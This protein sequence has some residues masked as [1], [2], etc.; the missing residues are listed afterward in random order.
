MATY[1]A[2]TAGEKDAD[3]PINVSLI[4]KLDQNPLAIAEGASGAPKIQ[5][6]AFDDDSINASKLV[7]ASVD[8]GTLNTGQGEV[9]TTLLSARLTL[10]GGEYG[11][12]PNFK[13]SNASVRVSAELCTEINAL[14]TYTARILLGDS[15]ESGTAYA[16]QRYINASP[17]HAID[18]LDYLDFIFLDLDNNGDVISGWMAT[19]PPWFHNGPTRTSPNATALGGLKRR[20]ARKVPES[21]RN[22]K[23]KKKFVEEFKKLEKEEIP[24]DFNFK[25]ADID[26]IP[27][28]FDENARN[29]VLIEP[30]QSGV[31][32]DLCELFCEGE[33]VLEIFHEGYLKIDNTEIN[34]NGSPPG[35]PMHAIKWK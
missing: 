27:H 17:P 25:N 31:Y 8:Q 12:Y 26:L 13:G 2:V 9:S 1:S 32:S 15:A 29:I 10:P 21:L 16:N 34:T 3:S 5:N 4:D 14:T 7:L 33:S 30:S 6:A 23:D 11:F 19:D 24:I 28:P 35:V 18:D 20:R 22:M